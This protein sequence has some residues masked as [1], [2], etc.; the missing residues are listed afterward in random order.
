MISIVQNKK[1]IIKMESTNW[2]VKR[3]MFHLIQ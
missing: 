3:D 1:K 2:L